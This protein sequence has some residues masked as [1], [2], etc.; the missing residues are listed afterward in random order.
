MKVELDVS[1]ASYTPQL[2]LFR[3]RIHF[4]VTLKSLQQHKNEEGL[5]SLPTFGMI[6]LRRWEEL[7]FLKITPLVFLKI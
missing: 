5:I 1:S 4:F 7:V 2:K 6:L 3:F